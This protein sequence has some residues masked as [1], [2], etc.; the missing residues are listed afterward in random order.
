MAA[1]PTKYRGLQMRSRIEAKWAAMF[2]RVGWLAAHWT[3]AANKTM[4][5]APA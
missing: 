1:I 3:A 2:D 5:K 4:W